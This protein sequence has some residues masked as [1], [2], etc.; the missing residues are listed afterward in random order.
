MKPEERD[1]YLAQAAR[2]NIIKAEMNGFPPPADATEH[3]FKH[4]KKQLLVD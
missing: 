4:Q 2:K 1:F 3:L